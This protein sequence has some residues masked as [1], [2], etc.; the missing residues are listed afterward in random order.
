MLIYTLLPGEAK[1]WEAAASWAAGPVSIDG[2]LAE[3]R[4]MPTTF[5][6]EERL[7]LGISN[8]AENLYLFL[9]TDDPQL[10]RVIRMGGITLWL[11]AKAK[12]KKELSFQYRGGPT[13]EEMKAAGMIDTSM[14][15]S[16][17][18]DR[19][20]RMM[21]ERAPEE[22]DGI[23]LI[24]KNLELEESFPPD[25]SYGPEI[26]YGF[27]H[28]F[29][30]YEI[31]IPLE[32]HTVDHYGINSGPGQ[33]ISIGIKWGGR[34]DRKMGD[35]KPSGDIGGISIGGDRGGRG[36][37]LG[38]MGGGPGGMNGGPGGMGRMQAPREKEFWVK[39]RLAVSKTHEKK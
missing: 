26:R 36:G 9:R 12:K 24:D 22:R 5:F 27:E 34:P 16:R 19:P 6:E 17:L 15:D 35:E 33:E 38:G 25:G 31:K 37:D 8:D 2:S 3:W 14:A 7:V 20:D 39:T 32:E 10:I 30:I 29:W 18:H 11:D 28:G 23:V 21:M 1:T 4:E 13:R